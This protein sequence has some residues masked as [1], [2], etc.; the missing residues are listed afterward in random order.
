MPFLLFVGHLY[1]A[2]TLTLTSLWRWIASVVFQWTLSLTRMPMYVNA[3][4]ACWLTTNAYRLNSQEMPDVEQR[5]Q[6]YVHRAYIRARPCWVLP[7]T[8]FKLILVIC[9]ECISHFSLTWMDFE[10][11]CS[12]SIDIG[13]SLW[14]AAD[15]CIRNHV[16]LPSAL[17][18]ARFHLVPVPL[19]S[20]LWSFHLPT[21]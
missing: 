5:L 19:L 1:R 14:A 7:L 10:L 13:L 11:L 9:S 2:F 4:W 18:F 6:M 17:A 20:L 21:C 8:D 16:Q 3:W 15:V 12:T